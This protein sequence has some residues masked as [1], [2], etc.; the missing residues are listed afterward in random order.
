MS[1][2]KSSRSK[3]RGVLWPSVLP[4]PKCKPEFEYSQISDVGMSLLLLPINLPSLEILPSALVVDT[5][6][7][8]DAQICYIASRN[9]RLHNLLLETSLSRGTSS[10][11]NAIG[12]RQA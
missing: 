9:S 11:L 1:L 6:Q 10:G 2:A 3:T 12:E 4:C 8:T 5:A 7:S